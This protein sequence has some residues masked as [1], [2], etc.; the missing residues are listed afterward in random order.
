MQQ[1][2]SRVCCHSQGSPIPGLQTKSHKPGPWRVRNQATQ[3][4]GP[5]FC[6][7]HA[8][9]QEL[10][11]PH[12]LNEAATSSV[13]ED[14]KGS[15]MACVRTDTIQEGKDISVSH[16]TSVMPPWK[17]IAR[18]WAGIHHIHTHTHMLKHPQNSCNSKVQMSKKNT[19]GDRVTL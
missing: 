10:F 8:V 11:C 3:Q 16:A 15:Q 9:N 14:S 5:S 19:V 17:L 1:V 4:N 7:T 18:Y 2:F 13:H 6:T 12:R